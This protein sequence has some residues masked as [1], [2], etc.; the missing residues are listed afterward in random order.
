MRS[1]LAA[2]D[3]LTA[4]RALAPE[5]QAR[6][7]EIAAHPPAARRS[8]TRLKA[9]GVF[10]MAMPKALGGP[11][12]T[13]REQCEAYEVSVPRMP[14]SL[15][16]E[17]RIGQRLLRR[18]ARRTGRAHAVSGPRLR[19]GRASATQRSRRTR[20]W[21]ISSLGPLDL[22]Q[23]VHAR[24]RDRPQDSWSPRTA[25]RSCVAVRRTRAS[26]SLRPRT[27]RS[28]T[29]GTAPDSPAAAATTIGSRIYSSPR[30]HNRAGRSAATQRTALLLL[31]HVPGQLA[32]DRAR[33]RAASDRCGARGRGEEDAHLPPPPMPLRQRPHARVALAK[34]EMTWRAARAFTYEDAGSDLG[35]SAVA[36]PRDRRTRAARW[37]CRCH[38]RSAPRVRLRSRCRPSGW[39]DGGVFSEDAA[40]SPARRCDHDERAPAAQR[41]LS[42]NGRHGNRRRPAADRLAQ[43]LT[44]RL[45]PDTTSAG[46]GLT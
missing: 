34:A 39:T 31:R 21:R 41:Q 4:V 11:E 18:A 28:S 37:R 19:D 5:I 42:R 44:V 9:A 10:R 8:R 32:R 22:W 46:Q 20:R 29:P 38:T 26:P 36:G 17:D 3:M 2:A 40:R 6:G 27:S 7:D 33:T 16:R 25:S 45:K 24:G 23:R 15:V 14:R 30:A 43:R 35:G 12:M 1:P 13:P